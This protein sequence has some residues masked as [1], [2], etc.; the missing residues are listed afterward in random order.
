M[1]F[2]YIL[3]S[4]KDSTYYVGFCRDISVRLKQH[5]SGKTK[6][7]KGHLPYYLVYKEE[8]KTIKE[9]KDREKYIKKYANVRSFLKNRVPPNFIRD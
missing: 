3:Q 9:A 4:K 7:T 8:Y 1:Y 5:N 6:Y 2:V